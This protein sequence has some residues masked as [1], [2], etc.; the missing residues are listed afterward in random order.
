[1]GALGALIPHLSVLLIRRIYF[2]RVCDNMPAARG[3]GAPMTRYYFN[4]ND[5]VITVPDEEGT[6][7][8]D[9]AAAVIEARMSANELA[10]AAMRAARGF[11]HGCVEISTED[12]IILHSVSMRAGLN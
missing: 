9:F 8:L 1:M 7:C 5:G 10:E 6:Y 3:G 4:I 12:G 11:G 2:G